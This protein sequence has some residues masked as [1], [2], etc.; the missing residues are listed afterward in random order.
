[1]LIVYKMVLDCLKNKEVNPPEKI[2]MD[3]ESGPLKAAKSPESWPVT[4]I[5]NRHLQ[6]LGL[7]KSY[8]SDVKMQTFVRYLWCLSISTPDQVVSSWDSF[9]KLNVPEADEDEMED[10]EEKAAAIA[11]H[12]YVVYFEST[13]ILGI[14]EY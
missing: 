9:V 13:W 11:I 10:K 2:H 5:G 7:Q 3:F 4:S 8:N 14:L 1:M 6:K 12:Q